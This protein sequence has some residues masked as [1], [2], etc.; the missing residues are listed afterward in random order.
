MTRVAHRRLTRRRAVA[1]I[2]V[3]LLSAPAIVANA[4]ALPQPSIHLRR[5]MNLWPWFSLTR[6]FPAPR[7]EY[8]WPP[9]QLDRPVPTRADLAALRS[10]GTDFVR[11]PVDPGPFLASSGAHH[12]AL[13]GELLAAIELSNDQ[14]LSVIVNLHPNNATHYWNANNMVGDVAAPLFQRYLGLVHEL[15]SRLSHFDPSRVCFEP[16]NE[17]PQSC[18]S[19]E[20]PLIQSELIGTARATAPKLT[21]IASGACGAM[22]DGLVALDPR[23]FDSN[24]IYTFHFYEPYVFSHQGAPWMSTEPMYR[25]LNTVPWPGSMGTKEKTLAAVAARMVADGE[26]SVA[27]KRQI[28]A[29]IERVLDEYFNARPDKQFI[30]RYFARVRAWADRYEIPRERVL[31]GEFGAL[32]SDERYVAA[33][34]PDRARYIRDVREVC[35]AAGM[36]WAFWNLFDGMGLAADDRSREFDPG[37][38]AALGLSASSMR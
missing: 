18:N 13:I 33:S 5:G 3:S 17:P 21:F 10:S 36:P 27:K 6:E 7:T 12:E 38:V 20:W 11:I 14:D 4:V 22:I 26:T 24:I 8:D 15:A 1:T 23:Q 34:A 35:E 31:L 28:G 25:Y 19:S 2:A 16:L 29:T 37:I 9:F 30:V 32:R